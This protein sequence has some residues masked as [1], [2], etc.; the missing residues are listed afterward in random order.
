MTGTHSRPPVAT[1]L[2][3]MG[4]VAISAYFI[5]S[6]MQGSHGIFRRVQVQADLEGLQL[7]KAELEAEL[8][9][10]G[11]LTERLSDHSLDLDL[12]DERARKVL[13]YLRAD[14]V[15]VH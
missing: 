14:E 5:F 8:A 11:N 15:V 7:R 3:M 10:I 2:F 12:L 4:A 9:A 6:A 13:G 1:A